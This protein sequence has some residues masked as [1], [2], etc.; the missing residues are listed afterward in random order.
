MIGMQA[1]LVGLVLGLSACSGG[2]DTGSSAGSIGG[3]VQAASFTKLASAYWIG[4]PGAGSSPVIFF[5][6]ES[7]VDCSTLVNPNWDKVGISDFQSLEIDVLDAELRDHTVGSDVD[8][9]Y[10]KGFYNPSA[11]SGSVTLSKVKAAESLKGSFDVAFGA[12]M[13]HGTFTAQFCADGV[14][15]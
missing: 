3:S 8:V 6:F 11:D 5:L 4:K 14:E 2:A 13:L 1:C 9:A 10:L 7:P 15:P 12:D